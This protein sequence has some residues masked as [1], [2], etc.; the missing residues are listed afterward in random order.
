MSEIE[1]TYPHPETG[2]TRLV[3][4]GVDL[5]MAARS[6]SI[7]VSSG[8]PRV[9]VEFFTA[10]SFRLCSPDADLIIDERVAEVLVKHGWRRPVA[11]GRFELGGVVR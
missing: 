11:E 10:E 3:V 7:E 4:D 1:I 2:G 8:R 9:T 6:A 5:S